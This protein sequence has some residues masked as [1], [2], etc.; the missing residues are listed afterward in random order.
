MVQFT[1]TRGGYFLIPTDDDKAIPISVQ[2]V[3]EHGDVLLRVYAIKDGFDIACPQI[4]LEDL[5]EWI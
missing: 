4:T 1:I 5:K 3:C 2:M